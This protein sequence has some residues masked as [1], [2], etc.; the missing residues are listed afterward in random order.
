MPLR[1]SKTTDV[2]GMMY[3]NRMGDNYGGEIGVRSV[4]SKFMREKQ[5]EH[6]QSAADNTGR[7]GAETLEGN[8][9]THDLRTRENSLLTHGYKGKMVVADQHRRERKPRKI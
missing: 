5:E 7:Y 8:S 3:F 1:V 2:P 4:C 6:R 9:R